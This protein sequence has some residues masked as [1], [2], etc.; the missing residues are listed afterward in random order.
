MDLWLNTVQVLASDA[1]FLEALMIL[2]CRM[3]ST[4]SEKKWIDFKLSIWNHYDFFKLKSNLS[5]IQIMEINTERCFC[6]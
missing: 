3:H 4:T 1:S 2:K 5:L 6:S